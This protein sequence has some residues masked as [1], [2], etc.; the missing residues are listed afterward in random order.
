MRDSRVLARR[1]SDVRE[2][3]A[4]FTEECQTSLEILA[5]VIE[6]SWSSEDKARALSFF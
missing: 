6:E 4:R 3:L 1:C 5:D 2:E